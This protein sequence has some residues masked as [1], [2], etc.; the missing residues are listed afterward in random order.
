MTVR[1]TALVLLAALLA[2]LGMGCTG[3]EAESVAPD[4]IK[5]AGAGA[6]FPA[7]L[8]EKWLEVYNKQNPDVRVTYDA[9]GSG[10]GTKQFIAGAVD[11]GASDAAMSDGEIAK[12][13]RGVQLAPVVAACSIVLAYN[14]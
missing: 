3:N 9:I 10:D 14:D 7:P 5:I 1:K 4:A 2:G 11:F 8:Y 6:T 13:E 12:V